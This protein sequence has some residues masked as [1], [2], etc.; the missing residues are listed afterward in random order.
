M[1]TILQDVRYGLRMLRKSPG[2][3]AIA[4][5]TL[6]LGIGATTAI[7][8][9]VDGVLLRPLPYDKPDQIVRLWEADGRG[10]RMDSTDPNFDDLR[11]QNHSLQGLAEYS[12]GLVSVSGGSEPTRTTAAMVSRDFFPLMRVQP[13][14]GRGFADEDQHFGAAP[15]ALVSYGYWRQYLNSTSDL[16]SSKLTVQ[17]QAVSVIGVLPP[18]FRFPENADIWM[19]R[20]LRRQLPSRSAHNWRLLGRLRDGVTPEQARAD[21]AA[22]AHQIKQ[23]YGLD[24]DMTDV[25]LARLQDAMT[26]D[27]RPALLILMG[28]VGFLLL[29]ACANVANLLLAQVSS[30][31]RELAIRMAIGAARGRLVRQFLV[32]ALLLSTI[33]GVLGVLLARWGV[34]AL[35]SL[36]PADLPSLNDVSISVPVLLFALAVLILVAFGLGAV[37]VLRTTSANV[38]HALAEHGRALGSAP[39]GQ[40]LVRVIIAGQIAITLVLVTGAGLLGRSLVRV[41]SIDPGFRSEHIVTANLALSYAEKEADKVRRVQFLSGLLAQLRTIPGTSEV[42]GTGSLPLTGRLSDGSY[43]VMSPN[44]QPP[45]AMEDLEKWFHQASRTGYANYSPVDG[46]YFRTLG[47]PLLRGRWFDDRDTMD[48]P[49]VAIVTQSLAQEKWPG[50]DPLG[51]RFEFGNMDGDLRPLTIVGVVGDVRGDS[52]EAPP[53]PT[54]Y[55]DY[56]QRPQATYRFSVVLRTNADPAVVISSARKII[57][58]LDPN[59]PPTFKTMSQVVSSSLQSRRFNLSLV[60]IFA[61]TALLLAMAGLYGVTA[62]AVSKRT[63]EFGIR[64]ALGASVGSVLRLVL[65]QGIVT[66]LVGVAIGLT[67]AFA[68]TRVLGS[69]LFDLSTTDPTTFTAVVLLLVSVALLACY[70]PARRAAKVDPMVALRYE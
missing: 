68:L 19:P 14:L 6:A 26:Q 49:H 20:E 43:V 2:F 39:R 21:L 12:A 10:H 4:V 64:I 65:K 67:G 40:G 46:G 9:V 66:A 13:V 56:R 35:L 60:A 48:A 37:S 29:I 22:I 62:Y 41:L 55:V 8:S 32:E 63:G 30:R 24:V 42:G 11:R 7:F 34:I 54:V 59:L 27:V 69:L 44:E 47:I 16:S 52:L 1:D 31:E 70:I 53:S 33:G 36:A 17:D 28:A 3:T 45:R 50:Q 57:H 18:G 38:Q 15:T 5:L 51:Q 23:Q 61:G 25:S 58:A